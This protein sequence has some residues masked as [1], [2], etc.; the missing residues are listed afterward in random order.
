MDIIFKPLQFGAVKLDIHTYVRTYAHVHVLHKDEVL[1][2]CIYRLG[3]TKIVFFLSLRLP[4]SSSSFISPS[5]FLFVTL[6][7]VLIAFVSD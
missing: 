1:F 2:K 4:G 3:N 5:L 6:W 7:Q